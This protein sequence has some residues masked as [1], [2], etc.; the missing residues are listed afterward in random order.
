M[1]FINQRIFY[2]TSQRDALLTDRTGDLPKRRPGRRGMF[3]REGLT[4][5]EVT[6]EGLDVGMGLI[7]GRPNEGRP[8]GG[9]GL[10]LLSRSKR[11]RRAARDALERK[12]RSPLPGADGTRGR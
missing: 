2:S 12:A 6:M 11:K 10:P 7:N 3:S 5:G 9:G 8:P 1:N 4:N